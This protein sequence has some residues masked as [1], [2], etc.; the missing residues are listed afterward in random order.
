MMNH[1]QYDR[2]GNPKQEADNTPQDQIKTFIPLHHFLA[3]LICI[4]I[5][6][7]IFPSLLVHFSPAL[8]FTDF[9]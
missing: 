5:G 6:Y 4:W 7:F 8:A 2:Y 1:E 9:L 3:F